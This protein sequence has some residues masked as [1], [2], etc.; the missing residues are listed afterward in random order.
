MAELD[1]SQL[2][3][4]DRSYIQQ[5][6]DNIPNVAKAD[7]ILKRLDVKL[8]EIQKEFDPHNNYSD[9]KRHEYAYAGNIKSAIEKKR[10]ELLK[11]SNAR[12]KQQNKD[13]VV[14]DSTEIQNKYIKDMNPFNANTMWKQYFGDIP[15]PPA[16]KKDVRSILES[17][18]KNKDDMYAEDMAEYVLQNLDEGGAWYNALI[19]AKN[20]AK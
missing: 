1:L 2:L 7:Y 20:G 5:Y 16:T 12:L 6:I 19:G 9:P 3:T 18:V 15:N 11:E 13:T 4:L 17:L 14:K 10:R 8:G